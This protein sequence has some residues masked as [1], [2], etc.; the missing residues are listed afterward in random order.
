MLYGTKGTTKTSVQEKEPGGF[1]PTTAEKV[2]SL[3]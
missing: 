3:I 2:F 1:P